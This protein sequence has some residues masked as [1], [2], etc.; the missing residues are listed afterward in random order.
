MFTSGIILLVSDCKRTLEHGLQPPC[1]PATWG[2][3]K[4]WPD[5]TAGT[6]PRSWYAARPEACAARA[7]PDPDHYQEMLGLC[8]HGRWPRQVRVAEADRRAAHARSS[9]TATV[10]ATRAAPTAIKWNCEPAMP[11][12]G[13]RWR[14]RAAGWRGSPP[15]PGWGVRGSSSSAREAAGMMSASESRPQAAAV[16]A[17]DREPTQPRWAACPHYAARMGFPAGKVC[18]R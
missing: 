10:A 4:G 12:R 3:R 2:H 16:R 13:P 15:C 17:A 6:E 9:S 5:L 11:P 8:L 1:R 14:C 7:A 18:L